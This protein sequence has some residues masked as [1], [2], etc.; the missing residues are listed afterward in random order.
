MLDKSK[1][2]LTRYVANAI[3]RNLVDT[4]GSTVG[5]P[6]QLWDVEADAPAN[7]ENYVGRS[8]GFTFS[9]DGREFLLT[10]EDVTDDQDTRRALAQEENEVSNI[11][12]GGG[13]FGVPPVVVDPDTLYN[14]VTYADED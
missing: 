11:P 6:S 10:I 9:N 12:F 8:L 5:S 13:E 1:Q 2:T 4:L 7:T 14:G 3:R